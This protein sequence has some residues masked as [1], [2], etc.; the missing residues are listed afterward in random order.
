MR[1]GWTLALL[2]LVRVVGRVM[3]VLASLI[4]LAKVR[5]VIIKKRIDSGL[6]EFEVKLLLQSI[7]NTRGKV[8]VN[9]NGKRAILGT[10]TEAVEILKERDKHIY[11]LVKVEPFNSTKEKMSVVVELPSG[12]LR[13]HCK[14]A[15]EII[16]ASCDKVLNLD[17]EI[18]PLDEE[19]TNHL[20]DTIKQFASEALRTLCF[21]Y[22][23]LENGLMGVVGVKDLVHPGVKK[24]VAMCPL[25]GIIVRMVTGD[26]INTTKVVARE[27]GILTDGDIAIEDLEF[28]EK[29]YDLILTFKQT[30]IR[31]TLAYHIWESG[32][33]NRRPRGI[34]PFGRIAPLDANVSLDAKVSLDIEALWTHNPTLGTKLKTRRSK[35]TTLVKFQ[36]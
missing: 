34:C 14:G 2:G 6:P 29:S 23:E 25:A 9:R 21:A 28:R 11:K 19:S 32:S 8:V 31:K 27:C 30:H 22:E 18:V 3:Y 36:K 33:Y 10:P 15:S 24:S 26:N 35:G 16:L 4:P 5:L 12:G 17:G 13:A 20:K 1:R 7:F